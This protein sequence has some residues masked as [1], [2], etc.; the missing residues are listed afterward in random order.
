MEMI[1]LLLAV[2]LVLSFSAIQTQVHAQAPSGS[3]SGTNSA[4]GAAI[5]GTVLDPDG[6]AV[7]RASVNL[8]TP[9]EVLQQS[10]SDDSGMYSF[11][12]LPAG[13]YRVAASAPGLGASTDD[14]ELQPGEMRRVDVPLKLSA[15][16]QGVVVSA[17]LGDVPAAQTASSVSVITADDIADHDAQGV[18]D[19]LREVPGV[20][21]ADSGR[22]GGVTSA[23][24]RGGNSN[25]DLVMVDGIPLNQFGGGLSFD[26]SPLP[27]DGV[28]QV[29]VVRGSQSALY[30]SDAV[31]GVVNIVTNKET[32][33][34][35][36]TGVL[37]GG[38]Y[39]TYRLATGAGGEYRGFSWAYDLSRL[40]SA[41]VVTND[42]YRNQSAIV[43]LGFSRSPRRQFDFHFFGDAN[44]AGVPGPYGSD[45]DHLFPGI[46]TVSRDKQYLYGYQ[47][48]EIE[49][50]SSRVRQ[51]ST[52]SVATDRFYFISPYGNSFENDLRIVANTRSEITIAPSDV[53][54][55]GFEYG[56]QQYED[57]YVVGPDSNPFVLPRTTLAFFAEDRWRP[58]GRWAVTLGVRVDNIDTGALLQDPNAPRP[59]IPANSITQVNPRGSLGYL[60]HAA[61]SQSS[62]GATRLH[63]SSGTGIRAPNG[64]ELGFTNNPDLKPERS[65]TTDAGIEQRFLQDRASVDVTYF[66]N[67][68]RDQI[69]TLGGSLQNLSTFSSANLNNSRAQGI[70]FSVRLRPWR[71]LEASAQYTWMDSRI[72]ALD[73]SALA[74][75]PFQV[76]EPLLERPRNSAAYDVTWRRG[77]LRLN[78]NGYVRGSALDLEPNDGAYACM[79]GLQCLFTDK[80]YVLANVGVALRTVAGVEIYAQ[81]NNLLNEKYE[82]VLGYPA[83]RLN[84]MSGIRLRFPG[85]R[86]GANTP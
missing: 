69:V 83:Y 13:T 54:A 85:E 30:G 25:Y 10:Q 34:P 4:H 86:R 16:N 35:E 36:F 38:S 81:V 74:A 15:V 17:A 18:A 37:E 31:A 84:F 63:A 72:L 46:D 53:L 1:R 5:Q 56:R 58:G 41:G 2:L 20:T 76:G 52:V 55:A 26:F 79:E 77:R 59:F 11:T 23:F 50:I 24:I 75:T 32:G 33:P 73:G 68:F 49:Q 67:S 82:E 14:L 19:M 51:V 44:S 45:P 61:S 78:T 47:L 43:S 29:E 3:G 64:F 57:T 9:T 28:A 80:G 62:W 6:K 8:S 48:S 71:S 40:D 39:D 65:I 7:P 22:R 21:V 66:Y 42:N 12:G 60:L 27:T 70:E